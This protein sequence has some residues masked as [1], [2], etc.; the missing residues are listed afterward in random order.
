[1]NTEQG[2]LSAEFYVV[3]GT[4]RPDAPS[5]VERQTDQEL[6]ERL[7]GGEFCYVLTARQMGKSSLMIRTAIRL[8]RAGIGVAVLD[9]TAL[10]QNV[11]AEQWYGGLL[12]Q[13]GHRLDLEDELTEFWQ[14]QLTVGPLQRWFMAIQ[15][16]VAP[17]YPEGLVI[18]IDEIDSV[19]SLPFSTDEFFAGVRECNN[20]RSDDLA[21]KSL[22]FCLLGVATPADL[23]LDKRIT[24]FNIGR[25]IEL[26]DFTEKEAELLAYGLSRGK[27]RNS[28]LLKRI[29]YWTGGHPY[30]TQ[31]L[32]QAAAEDERVHRSEDIDRLCADLFFTR[33]AQERDDNLIFVREHLLR[34]E[35][36]RASLL[37]LYQKIRN[38]NRV[39]DDEANALISILRLSGISQIVDGCL[40]VRNRI[41]SQVFNQRWIA[42]NMPGAEL[43]RQRTAY[44]RGLWR[45]ALI[46]GLI[47]TVVGSLALLAFNQS[48][49]AGRQAEENRQLLYYTQMRLAQE[50]WENAN[51]DRVDELLKAAMPQP[52]Q[53]DL[54][55]FEWYQLWRLTHNDIWRLKGTHQVTAV[56]FTPDGKGL[57]IGEWQKAISS[58]S[59]E[60]ALKLYDLH[61]QSEQSLFQAPSGTNFSH[62]VF[63]T[64]LQYV[65]LGGADQI[66]TLRDMK[67]GSEIMALKGHKAPISMIL[68]SP[69][70]D[71]LVTADMESIVKIWDLATGQERLTLKPPRWIRHGSFSPDGRWLATAD[72]SRQVRLWDTNTGHELAPLTSDVEILSSP[73]FFPDGRRMLTASMNGSLQVWDLNDRQ[74]VATLTGHSGYTQTISFSPNGQ[75]FATGNYDRTVRLWSTTTY[76]ELATIKGHGAAV[77]AVAWSSDGRRLVT[78]S[79]DYSVKIWDVTAKQDIVRPTDM[80]KSYKAAAFTQ[81]REL[82]ALGVTSDNQAKLWNLSTG[83]V[84]ARLNEPGDNILYAVFSPDR[85]LLATGGMDKL[86][87]LW[88]TTTGKVVRYLRAHTGYIYSADF[89]PDGKILVSGGADHA[90]KLWEVDTGQELASLRGEVDNSFRAAFSP[91]GKLLA[92]ACRDGRVLLWDWSNRQILTTFKG[93]IATVKSIAFSNDGRMLATGGEDNSLRLWDPYTGRELRNLGQSDFVQR[94]VFSPDNKRIVTGSVSGVVKLWDLATGQEL[95]TLRGHKDDVTSVSFSADGSYLASCANDG[96]VNLWYAASVREVSGNF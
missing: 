16:V 50:E 22:T 19:R 15:E 31:R 63:S 57:A 54:R 96:T 27:K 37:D 44:R 3:G 36:D 55:G 68:L 65:I 42:E 61:N 71:K 20:Q 93:H 62:I 87:K 38:K 94:I 33:R 79:A 4:L 26:Y 5:Y 53:S 10:G 67:S 28:V 56:A 95:M 25:R 90:L 66:V 49:R 41:Y 59:N 52:G 11:S 45:A 17:C 6:F 60:Y 69:V 1:M 46:G 78:G 12:L 40:K 47:L 51:I 89:S 86:V 23:I 85:K 64:K 80:V 73:A 48:Q 14:L 18:F 43:R 29:L 82:L 84:I 24:P 7:R 81:S 39:P 72:E 70:G 35:I 75:C 77:L 74:V 34:S 76:K 92:S 32:C 58:G 8:R 91:N 88:D 2:N 83:Q 21:M 9:L 30:L 13:L